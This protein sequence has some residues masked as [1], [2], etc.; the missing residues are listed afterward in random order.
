MTADIL[1][2]VLKTCVGERLPDL[3]DR[4]LLLVAFASGGRRRSEVSSLRVEQ[5]VAQDPVPADPK[6]PESPTLPCL[7]IQLGRTAFRCPK[8]CSSRSTAPCNRHR[9]ITT[10]SSANWDAPRG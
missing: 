4:A 8:P 6:D 2:A 9:A 3:R 7:K 10:T 1:G 5:I